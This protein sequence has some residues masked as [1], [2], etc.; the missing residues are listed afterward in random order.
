MTLGFRIRA[1]TTRVDAALSVGIIVVD[2]DGEL[3]IANDRG[4]HDGLG[5]QARHNRRGHRRRHP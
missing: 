1:V 5:G 2:A 3:G 4:A